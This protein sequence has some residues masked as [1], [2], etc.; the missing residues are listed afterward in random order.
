MPRLPSANKRCWPGLENPA[1]D[2][3][4]ALEFLAA[5]VDKG[6]ADAGLLEASKELD[7]IRDEPGYRDL[8]EKIKR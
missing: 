2:R 6:F 4:G 1:N 7:R 8:L 3:K 5:A